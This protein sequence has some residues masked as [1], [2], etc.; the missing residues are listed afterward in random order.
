MAA[1]VELPAAARARSARAVG[2]RARARACHARS[3][4][5][6]ARWTTS[7]LSVAAGEQRAI[8]G[9]N[10]AGKTTLFNAITGDFPPTAGRVH[11]F[12][13]DMTE[14]PPH[15]RIRTRAAAHL[16]VVAAVSRADGARQP[17]PRG[18]RRDRGRFNMRRPRA[19]HPRA[20]RPKRLLQP[21][22]LDAVA[23]DAGR[24]AVARPAAA[25]RDRH[26]IGRRAATDSVRRAGRRAVAC[27]TPRTRG[28][29]AR[30][31]ARTWASC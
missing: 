31:A 10:G 20:S 27:R 8:L 30:A 6:C 5:R 13:E 19:R 23:D 4:A 7:R 12:G 1:V 11:F 28:A 14:L 24:N 29:A 2:R 17:V 21:V 16:S 9:A 3:S 26:G 22:R 18:A 15:E 25:A